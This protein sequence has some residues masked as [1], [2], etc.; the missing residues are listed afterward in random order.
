MQFIDRARTALPKTASGPVP[1]AVA[2]RA[3]DGEMRARGCRYRTV[4]DLMTRLG[5]I[6]RALG[7]RTLDDLTTEALRKWLD[8]FRG[9]N[10]NKYRG[11][12]RQLYRLAIERDLITHNP[13]DKIPLAKVEPS[14]T[15]I[16]TPEEVAA[17]MQAAQT[18]QG[19][20]VIRAVA[21][22]L[23]AFLRPAEVAAL[24]E[25]DITGGS[26][27]VTISKTRRR[28]I[29]PISDQCRAWLD[30]GASQPIEVSRKA[31]EAVWRLSGVERRH[32]VL[33]HTGISY[34]LAEVADEN[35]VARE[36]GNSPAMIYAHYQELVTAEELAAYQAIRP[37][38]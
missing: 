33:R 38:P 3:L 32:N 24:K 31:M 36:A 6:E 15:E 23:F 10:R 21:L 29:V 17:L 19:G 4:E 35:Q 5:T 13:A 20:L 34:R 27:R 28:R 25:R 14:P 26:I 7:L 1:W 11:A 8:N 30:A 18:Y 16:L 12:V 22:R 37:S 2:I 9:H